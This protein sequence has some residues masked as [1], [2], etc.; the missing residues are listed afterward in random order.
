M[1]NAHARFGR[2]VYVRRTEKTL[3][4]IAAYLES[5]VGEENRAHFVSVIGGDANIGALAAAFAGGDR[6]TVVDPEGQEAI[7]SL[8]E[9]PACFRGSVTVANRKRPLRH[10]VAVSQEMVG[11]EA[12]ERLLL[13]DNDPMF[14]WS[15]LVLHYGLP[16]MPE[17]A[18]W[19]IAELQ[20]RKRIQPLLGFG[21]RPIAVRVKRQELLSLIKRGVARGALRFPAENGPADWPSLAVRKSYGGSPPGTEN[22]LVGEHSELKE[23][24]QAKGWTQAHAARRLGVTQAYLSML[25]RGRRA[26]SRSFVNKAVKALNVSATAIPLRS[27]ESAPPLNSDQLRAEIA[28]LGY[29]GFAYLG[30]RPRKNPAEVLLAAL[31]QSDLDARVAEAVPWLIYAYPDMDWD[32]L[33]RHAKLRDLQNRLGYAAVL[34]RELARRAGEDERVRKIARYVG[35]LDR[36]RL[37]REDTFCHDSMT[38]A[39][40]NFLRE[41]RPPEAT[42]WNLLTD[43]TVEHLKH[44]QQ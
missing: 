20:R 42:Y 5:W 1:K 7:V 36:S 44:A 23:T 14:V 8:G 43:L 19:V 17:W 32:W 13:I 25:E 6:F 10:L 27:P 4:N 24:R 30:G 34:A 40:R 12:K 21:Y 3:T 18:A 35:L 29:P 41:H 33:V 16:A 37:V 31:E 9:K 2:L 22:R 15:S 11:T 26:P 28:A 38:T 39:E